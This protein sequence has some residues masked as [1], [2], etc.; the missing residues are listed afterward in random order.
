MRPW[1]ASR[2]RGVDGHARGIFSL[3]LYSKRACLLV[4]MIF[5]YALISHIVGS[6]G[7]V[8]ILLRYLFDFLR[9][10]IQSIECRGL[11]HCLF[12]ARHCDIPNKIQ[13]PLLSLRR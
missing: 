10:Q 8:M 4:L 13:Q 1:L 9:D 6:Y 12:G 5:Y 2:S 11:R 7:T 3:A